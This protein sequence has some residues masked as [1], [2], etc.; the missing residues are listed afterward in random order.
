MRPLTVVVLAVLVAVLG[1]A[2]V[3]ALGGAPTAGGDLSERW[4]SETPRD[5]QRNHHAVG[6]GPAGET[7]VAPVSAVPGDGLAADACSLVR[8][9][10]GSGE[11]VWKATVPPEDCYTH[12]LTQPAIADIDGNGN[13]EVVAVTTANNTTLVAY[14][15]ATGEELFSVSMP[16]YAGYSQPAVA[17]LPA[18]SG[19]DV[20]AVDIRGNVAA[21]DANGTVLW[22]QSLN[23]TTYAE[24]VVADFDGDGTDEIAVSTRKET[25]VLSLSGDIEHRADVTGK[26]LA[27]ANVDDDSAIE[28]F[29]TQAGV[30]TALDGAELTVEWEEPIDGIPRVHAVGQRDGESTLY[31]AVSGQRVVAL[32]AADGDR[33]WETQLETERSMMPAPA[34]ADVSGDGDSEV[35]AVTNGGTAVVLDPETGDELAA[36][37]RDVAVWTFPTLADLDGDGDAEILVRYGDGRVVVLDYST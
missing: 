19:L 23:E 4:T 9:D 18:T 3:F 37:E 20:V 31:V 17:N 34:V 30:V 25:V 16:A 35:V 21:V 26:T 7:V 6:V 2:T 29:V 12:G 24:P 14:D 15:G 1:G 36:Y 27:T 22:R 10:S 5:N 33:R 32:S 8:L 11:T 28:L 13:P